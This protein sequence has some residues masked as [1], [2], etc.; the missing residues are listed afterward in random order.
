[1]KLFSI[2]AAATFVLIAPGAATAQTAPTAASA[3]LKIGAVIYGP[4]GSEVGKIDSVASDTIVID[5]GTHKATLPRSALGSSAKGPT[6]SVTKA[7]IDAQI[8]AALD[9]ADAE[10]SAALVPGA[11][12]RG[13]S[14]ALIGTIK[15]LNG[16]QVVV[17]RASGPVGLPKR[18]FA[19]GPQGLVISLTAAELDVAAKAATPQ[20]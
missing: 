6:V 20:S 1:M 18:A 3:D 7:Q 13:K 17:D 11:E 5:T 9:K 10:L 14:G 15:E 12:V 16:D 2:F 8:Q 4:Q 19:K